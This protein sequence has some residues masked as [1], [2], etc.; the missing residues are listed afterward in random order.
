MCSNKEDIGQYTIDQLIDWRNKASE[1]VNFHDK[2]TDRMIQDIK[3]HEKLSHKDR[4]WIARLNRAI[5]KKAFGYKS[6]I[7]IS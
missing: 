4:I 7:Y 2:T 3:W 5:N 1:R 6:G